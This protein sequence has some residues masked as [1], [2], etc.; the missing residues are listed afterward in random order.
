MSKPRVGVLHQ[1]NLIGGREDGD[2]DSHVF[3]PDD[4]PRGLRRQ[5]IFAE[6]ADEIVW[7][8]PAVDEA[9]ILAS[10]MAVTWAGDVGVTVEG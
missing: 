9:A 3:L 10:A 4:F 7:G 5:R 1:T 6:N 2:D 8:H